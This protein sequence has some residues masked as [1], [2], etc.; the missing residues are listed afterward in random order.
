MRSLQ[1]LLL[2]AIGPSSA[3]GQ[4]TVPTTAIQLPYS[5][6]E[7]F[8]SALDSADYSHFRQGLTWEGP[9]SGTDT[10]TTQYRQ[11]WV[12]DLHGGVSMIARGDGSLMTYRANNVIGWLEVIPFRLA[13][14]R[15]GLA[16][17]HETP[18]GLICRTTT[19]YVEE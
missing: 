9:I 2:L 4:N 19:F 7:G 15:R 18:C 16:F 3:Q 17:A 14:G 13:D 12:E 6:A 5:S 11:V 10:T 1:I 8:A